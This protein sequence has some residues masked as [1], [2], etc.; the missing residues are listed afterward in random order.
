MKFNVSKFRRNIIA[1]LASLSLAASGASVANA[2][3][4]STMCTIGD[5]FGF[6]KDVGV[7][8]LL[9]VGCLNAKEKAENSYSN[10]DMY[11]N[12]SFCMGI[13]AVNSAASAAGRLFSIPKNMNTTDA[14]ND[15]N[16]RE[17]MKKQFGGM[18]MQQNMNMAYGAQP[19][20]MNMAY[21]AQPQNMNMAYGAAPTGV[22][23]RF[24][25]K[26]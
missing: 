6:V 2:T 18:P 24:L 20:N 12:I 16:A 21:G 10:C 8:V 9:G 19:Q 3:F 22:N 13:G 17:K 5:V 7:T 15:Y 11:S 14:L 23:Q 4:S 26:K 1:S 25:P